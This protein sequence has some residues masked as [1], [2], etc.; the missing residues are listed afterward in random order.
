MDSKVDYEVDYEVDF[1]YMGAGSDPGSDRMRGQTPL[2]KYYLKNKELLE[3]S[4]HA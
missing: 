1:D 2:R 3:E 4:L